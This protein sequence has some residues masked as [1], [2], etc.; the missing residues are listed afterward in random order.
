MAAEAS[1]VPSLE[2]V[3]RFIKTS[4]EATLEAFE[5]M[6]KM[7]EERSSDLSVRIPEDY[8]GIVQSLY[9]RFKYTKDSHRSEEESDE[10]RAKCKELFGMEIWDQWFR[11]FEIVFD[12]SKAVEPVLIIVK[13]DSWEKHFSTWFEEK[14]VIL[15]K[16]TKKALFKYSID[17]GEQDPDYDMHEEFQKEFLKEKLGFDTPESRFSFMKWLI[18]TVFRGSPHNDVLRRVMIP[19]NPQF[20]WA[21][22]ERG[23]KKR[24][25]QRGRGLR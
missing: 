18:E 10:L 14:L 22:F 9:C 20:F 1:S 4:P 21:D 7:M 11:A 17:T 23:E 8:A 12:D 2:H 25:V 3:L 24:K 19:E 6:Q 15:N 13:I 16:A 5:E